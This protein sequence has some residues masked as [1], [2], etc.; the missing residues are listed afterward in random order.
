MA[1]RPRDRRTPMTKTPTTNRLDRDA[2]T[3]QGG[4]RETRKHY[5][6]PAHMREAAEVFRNPDPAELKRLRL[7][8]G[9]R[10]SE[11]A[12]EIDAE[13]DRWESENVDST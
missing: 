10:W 13:A 5:R 11:L 1:L 2:G 4:I 12:D 8:P 3:A 7:A 6:N 9:S